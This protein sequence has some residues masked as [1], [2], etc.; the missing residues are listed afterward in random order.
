MEAFSV[1]FVV[2]PR[3][4]RGLDYYTNTVFEIVSEGLGSQN[5]ICGGGAYEGLVEELGGPPTYGVGFAIGEDRLIEVLPA[6]S[7][8]RRGE[9]GPVVV[10]RL[11]KAPIEGGG[12]RGAL[13]LAERLRG[14]DIPAIE[15]SGGKA[16]KAFDLAEKLGSPAVAF[17]GDDELAAGTVT[18]KL[19]ESR[20]QVTVQ[21]E[22]AIAR[23][24]P[25]YTEPGNRD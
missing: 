22:E 1:P 12:E 15:G 21:P 3:L 20:E 23:L 14:A 2:E 18:V 25:L 17:L 5:A 16:A 6:D 19:L 7:P 24:K 8:A 9:P 13:A 4:V 11:G 10:V